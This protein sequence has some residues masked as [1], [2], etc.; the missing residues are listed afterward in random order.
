MKIDRSKIRKSSSDVPSDCQKLIQYLKECSEQELLIQLKQINVWYFGKCEL[1]HWIDVLDRFDHI[2][3]EVA[4]PVEGK[5]WLNKRE[6]IHEILK[7]TSLLIEHSYARHLYNSVEHLVSLMDCG[8]ES[9]ILSVLNLI[10]VF[11]KRSNYLSRMSSENRKSLQQRLFTLG[12]TWGGSEAGYALDQCCATKTNENFKEGGSLYFEYYLEESSNSE[13][14][15][16]ENPTKLNK[17]HSIYLTNLQKISAIPGEVME[18]ILRE[19]NVPKDVQISL[20]YRLRLAH[21]MPKL[22]M[23]LHYVQLR[24]QAISILVYSNATDQVNSLVYDGFVEEIVNTLE[25][26]HEGNALFEVK[27]S[28]LKTLTAI[29]H[30]D[31][32]P[33]LNTIIEYTGASSYHGFLPTLVRKCI[34]QMTD[35][36]NQDFPQ[37]YATALFSF[38]YHLAS[39]E[40]GCEALVSCG[41]MESLLKVVRWPGQDDHI[42]FVTRAV[43][44]IDLITNLDMASFQTHNGLNVLVDRL[45]NEVKNCSQFHGP[46]ISMEPVPSVDAGQIE[47]ED[48]AVAKPGS[49]K[50]IEDV[51]MND[52]S[53]KQTSSAGNVTIAKSQC[54]P[55]RAA[56]LKSI[57]NFL[58]KTI[59][60]PAFADYT[61]SL[62]EE[63]LQFSLKLIISNAEYYGALLFLLATDVVTVYIFHEPSMLSSLQES[64]LTGV[65]LKSLIMKDVPAT[66]EN[67]AS[68]PNTLSALCLNTAG[69]QAFIACKPFERLFR[70]LITPEYLPAMK[71]RRSSDPQGDT[72]MHLGT[73][74][75]ELMRHQPTLKTDAMK[76]I[77]QLLVKLC[78]MGNDPKLIAFHA[79]DKSKPSSTK[80]TTTE[81]Q[82]ISSSSTL[83][84]PMSDEDMEEEFGVV[85][86]SKIEEPNNKPE[87]SAKAVSEKRQYIPMID[88]LL[89]VMKFLENI[90][91]NNGT[92]DHCTEFVSL[93]GLEPLLDLLNL[94]NMPLEFPLLPACQSL[95]AVCKSIV[96]LSQ[97][98]VLF[99]QALTQLD[100][101]LDQLMPLCSE[102]ENRGSI[103]LRELASNEQPGLAMH[104]KS[105]TPLLHSMS[106]THAYINMFVHIC[107]GSQSEVRTMS[108]NQWGSE[109]GKRVLSKLSVLYTYLVWESSV[110]LT[111]CTPNLNDDERI[112]FAR[113]DLNRLST[114]FKDAKTIKEVTSPESESS[115]QT[116]STLPSS[117]IAQLR[118]IKWL[119]TSS[120]HLGRALAELFGLLVHQCIAPQQ[121]LRRHPIA[122]QTPNLPSLPA[123]L[124]A[125]QL[126][127]IL[128]QGLSWV[129]P[130]EVAIPRLRMTFY[131]CAV[132]F[133]A[134]M[135][136][137][138]K[139]S[140]YHLM[141]QQFEMASGLNH[142]FQRFQW[143]LSQY[144]DN[145]ITSKVAE[146][147]HDGIGEFLESWLVLVEKMVNVKTVLESAH[148]LP[149]HST[150]PGFIKFNPVEFLAK[151]QKLAFDAVKMLWKHKILKLQGTN[152]AEKMLK[153]LCHIFKGESTV[154]E[155]LEKQQATKAATQP[156]SK[157]SKS[158]T[159]TSEVA[160]PS[161]LVAASRPQR[162]TPQINPGYVQQIVDMGF[163]EDQA[164]DALIHC[165]NNLVQATDYVLSHPMPQA[166]P[167]SEFGM[168]VDM[169]EEDMMI[170]AIALSL[171]ENILLQDQGQ[172]SSSSSVVTS[173][174]VTTTTTLLNQQK[175]S[176]KPAIVAKE[177]PVTAIAKET[178]D[179]FTDE[180]L[181]GCLSMLID[182]PDIVHTTYDLISSVGSRN[183]KLWRCNV[184]QTICKEVREIAERLLHGAD[185]ISSKTSKEM[186][187]RFCT[188]EDANTLATR[189]HLLVLLAQEIHF[190]VAL[191]LQ[192]MKVVEHLVIL[193][194]AVNNYLIT[195]DRNEDAT[196]PRWLPSLVLLLDQYERSADAQQRKNSFECSH[197]WKWFDDRTGRWCN[198]SAS[199]NS[200]IDNAYHNGDTS[201]RFTAG[202]RRYIVLFKVMVQINEDTSNRRPI[203]LDVMAGKTEQD[204]SS[205]QATAAAIDSVSSPKKGK[206]KRRSSA[207]QME[208]DFN[209]SEQ[210]QQQSKQKTT[211]DKSV[212]KG[213]TILGLESYQIERIV[214]ACSRLMAAPIDSASLNAVMRLTLRL[215]RDYKMAAVFSEEQGPRAL[216]KLTEAS[217]FPGA[218]L[219]ATLLLRHV[220]EDMNTLQ[221]VLDT[222]VCSKTHGVGNIVSGVGQNS[223]GTKELN[224]VMRIL[225]PAACRC[226]DLFKATAKKLLRLQIKDSRSNNRR[227]LANDDSEW[228]IAPN[229]P[230]ILKVVQSV[231]SNIN[232]DVHNPLRDLVA[233]LL[234]SLVEL[235]VQ[236][237]KDLVTEPSEKAAKIDEDTES[238]VQ[239]KESEAGVG[240]VSD[241][242]EKDGCQRLSSGNSQDV[243]ASQSLKNKTKKASLL[244]LSKKKLFSKSTLLK[245][246]AEMAK[247]YPAVAKLISE[248]VYLSKGSYRMLKF[249]GSILAFIFD[250]LLPMVNQ[251]GTDITNN[252]SALARTLL[253]VIGSS[254]QLADVQNS[255]IMELKASLSRALNLQES[256]LKHSRLQAIF[257]LIV[258]IIESSNPQ[259][260]PAIGNVATMGFIKLLIRKGVITDLAKTPHSLDL[261]SP[262]LVTTINSMLKPLEKLS[263]LANHQVVAGKGDKD[264]AKEATERLQPSAGDQP[265]T[266]VASAG[267]ATTTTTTIA[268]TSDIR[269]SREIEPQS[270]ATDV[271]E[272]RE[273]A[274]NNRDIQ[275]E[276]QISS[277]ERIQ[278]VSVEMAGEGVDE[279][280]DTATQ[281]HADN[282]S[283]MITF[284][285]IAHSTQEHSHN[286]EDGHDE[287]VDH[288]IGDGDD[289]IIIEEHEGS[290]MDAEFNADAI[291][292]T[293][294]FFHDDLDPFAAD[295][296]DNNA[297]IEISFPL[298]PYAV[299]VPLRSRL[300]DSH[301]N[302]TGTSSST[303]SILQHPLL[304]R[305]SNTDTRV[306]AS[307]L[308][309]GTRATRNDRL[310]QRHTHQTH[311]LHIHNPQAS[312]SNFA[313][314]L[315][316]DNIRVL[317]RNIDE[318][319]G[320]DLLVDLFGDNGDSFLSP[321]HSVPN[322]LNRWE[323]ECRLLDGMG[324]HDCVNVIKPDIIKYLQKLQLEELEVKKEEDKKKKAEAAEKA[325]KN[326]STD[327]N[328]K[329][330]AMTS[331]ATA[332]TMTSSST[333]TTTT[334]SIS[335]N[336]VSQSASE[337]MIGSDTDG[338]Q[339][340]VQ[341]MPQRTSTTTTATIATSQSEVITRPQLSE[342]AFD[343]LGARDSTIVHQG[344]LQEQPA[345]IEEQSTSFM[346]EP[347]NVTTAYRVPL[348]A[349]YSSAPISVIQSAAPRSDGLEGANSVAPRS[350]TAELA[351]DLATAI[352]SQLTTSSIIPPASTTTDSTGNTLDASDISSSQVASTEATTS[353]TTTTE[354]RASSFT[355]SDDQQPG[356]SG[357]QNSDIPEGVDP[358]FLAALP[359]TI[360]EEVLRDHLGTR[361]RPQPQQQSGSQSQRPEGTLTD[362]SPEFLAALPPE[363]QEE[364]LEQQRLERARMQAAQTTPDQPVDAAAFIRNL[365]PSLRRQ[366]LADMD[367]SV[368]AILPP[369]VNS[370]AMGLRRELEQRQAQY[371]QERAFDQN[372]ALSMFSQLLRHSGD[373]TRHRATDGI[374][375]ARVRAML[376]GGNSGWGIR[377]SNADQNSLKKG[378]NRQLIDADSVAC[379]IV[380][381]FLDEPK[382][383]IG[384][385]HRVLKN[386]SFHKGTRLWIIKAL[387]SVINR[388]SGLDQQ[389][390][391]LKSWSKSLHQKHPATSSSSSSKR[392]GQG[393]SLDQSKLV[394]WLTRSL[395][396]SFGNR[397]DLFD[398][399]TPPGKAVDK[400]SY[401]S[402]HPHAASFV[403]KHI[404][405]ALLFLAKNFPSSFTPY[406]SKKEAEEEEDR[407]KKGINKKESLAEEDQNKL[408]RDRSTDM[409]FWN[410]LY[411]LNSAGPGRKG[412]MPMK[413]NKELFKDDVT[414][415]FDNSPLAQLLSMLSH[416]VIKRNTTLIDKLLRLL[417]VISTSLP[418]ASKPDEASSTAATNVIVE[419]P[420]SAMA[421]SSSPQQQEQQHQQQQQPQPT[422]TFAAEDTIVERSPLVDAA[423]LLTESNGDANLPDQHASSS[424]D[425][426]DHD[427][428]YPGASHFSETSSVTS[429]LFVE[430]SPAPVDPADH[431]HIGPRSP[432]AE[433]VISCLSDGTFAGQSDISG[434]ATHEEPMEIDRASHAVSDTSSNGTR[435]SPITVPII[436]MQSGHYH[437]ADR[438]AKEPV[439]VETQLRLAVNVLTSGVCSEDGLEDTTTL[440]LQ[441]S[442]IDKATRDA[443]LSLL[444]DGARDI[445]Y[446]LCGEIKRLLVELK[447]Y[448][449]L[450][451]SDKDKNASKDKKG[452][453]MI[454]INPAA[455]RIQPR[456]GR[457]R[458]QGIQRRLFNPPGQRQA[459]KPVI[460]DLHLPS[461][462]NLTGKRSCQSLLLRVLKVI[463]QLREAAKKSLNK[464]GS[465]PRSDL[466]RG[467]RLLHGLRSGRESLRDVVAAL[468]ADVEAMYELIDRYDGERTNQPSRAQQQ[469]QQQA[470]G[471]SAEAQPEPTAS[472]SEP[473]TDPNTQNDV[474][475]L[476]TVPI[477]PRL[478]SQIILDELWD[479]IGECLSE[480]AETSDAN[481]VLILQPAVEAFFIV[482]AADKDESTDKN[483]TDASSQQQQQHQQ[484]QQDQSA[485]SLSSIDL[486]PFSP[487]SPGPPLSPS[488]QSSTSIA[489]CDLAPDT[490]KFLKF[491]ETHRV[492]LNQIL[493]QSTTPLADGPFAVLV[494]HTRL[495]DFD[496]KRRYFR[497]ELEKL[498]KGVRREDMAVHVRREHV[499]EDSYRELHRK[500]KD[501][502]KNRLYIVFDGEEG[503]DA[504]GLLREWY[505]IIARE[506][507]NPNYALFTTSQG[508]RNTYLPSRSSHC[509][510]NHLSYFKFVG[511]IV[512]KAI[513]DNKLLD[514][515]FTRSFYKHILDKKVNYTDME[516][517]DY[518]FYQ[519]LVYLLDNEVKE[520]GYELTFSVEVPVFGLNEIH[521]LK[522]D[523][524]NVP[525]TEESKREYVKLVCQE[526]MTGSIRQQI[527]SFLEGFYEII[528]K[529][530][531]SI[532][533][534]QELELL[535]AGLPTIDIEDLRANTEYHKYDCNSL[536]IQ[537]FW[538]ALRAFDQADRAKFLQFVTGTSKVPLQG[539][540][541]LEGM[542]GPQKFQIHRDDRSTER[543]PS[544]HTC[545]NQLDLPA[546]NT[547]EKLNMQLLKAI[548][549]CPEGF[550]L[551]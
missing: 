94:A 23:R 310:G 517:E 491:A 180:L 506:M 454:V 348:P 503:Q 508:D 30:L 122:L 159:T 104:H 426:A 225:G 376:P 527:D 313:R 435:A 16:S 14:T 519:G 504:G 84:D 254:S 477:L 108:V 333:T 4:K 170:R 475:S 70:I 300:M 168:D 371:L 130:D 113:D 411:R 223:I 111:L 161:S 229:S 83:D 513:Y 258:T 516:A 197:I 498:D 42:T 249:E 324:V 465:Q 41:L 432:R 362:V 267:E 431:L 299:H 395:D 495:L 546:Y 234:D 382:L 336:S 99:K 425:D 119:L 380:L 247:T 53:K 230:Q 486:P 11:S 232:P 186:T 457:G 72:A 289:A 136:F 436:A 410:I 318:N 179:V 54:L 277:D 540:A 304:S 295:N 378:L 97:D 156:E 367:D 391:S 284:S 244:Y 549:E 250:C 373:R 406:L 68:L 288:V 96:V 502:L 341:M 26:Q 9:I 237:C 536:Q 7:F 303:N 64:G 89:N 415:S 281:N 252:V 115:S 220:V 151:T 488:R 548:Q 507:F 314:I 531:I 132:G 433:S 184:T 483:K 330:Q 482:H 538:R 272:M 351:T 78:E 384:R 447:E 370:E 145:A 140:P 315:V 176:E 357:T 116:K 358:S 413:T 150:S 381:L 205:G 301:A 167:H 117:R 37:Q 403:N 91:S 270:H 216:L 243:S 471:S 66:R 175:K 279:S 290:E 187:A 35:G 73:A 90:L 172:A 543:L 387:I 110:L 263:S 407:L 80:Q 515:Y 157:T 20:L 212:A 165:G 93:G 377:Q 476:M 69:L 511:R 221:H 235:H 334:S 92:D 75:D 547:F 481:A 509:N 276:F 544:A 60:D 163:T 266:T 256:K 467:M 210:Q 512:A 286:I 335:Q 259:T 240:E 50:D 8:D 397:V 185:N 141:L 86:R 278:D 139:E 292:D 442:K 459:T 429:S 48:G 398:I 65:V 350:S 147:S 59:P 329:Q 62:M 22:E 177:E 129:C 487:L 352:L 293:I 12:E 412:K 183:G 368:L 283:M 466:S 320:D 255:L 404:V 106:A 282:D 479:V 392:A 2:L 226:P 1:Y 109:L 95:S 437:Q 539:F 29:I 174:T 337:D 40:S 45:K 297:T 430:S 514:C 492:V 152:I 399:R 46:I 493:R 203:M 280:E 417:A 182:L 349:I 522:P 460:F 524:R 307:R 445:A 217:S 200:S 363:V 44:V 63:S 309:R 285:G 383:N 34:S 296:D 153:I 127:Q 356:P 24:L 213:S 470:A 528:P 550:G 423:N 190:P 316:G 125:E 248:H 298:R 275:I 137:D 402:I 386:V 450:H 343:D 15:S 361:S 369:D 453:P 542:N 500:S 208:T 169:S 222:V 355:A 233:V 396:S 449:V 372:D 268:A 194:E 444:L 87:E 196:V 144:Q 322:A 328:E 198:Y 464:A 319:L 347:T 202:R 103:L 43:R 455:N 71:R 485:A 287:A 158:N 224:F 345:S 422:V 214:R 85:I 446:A 273:D 231:K 33:R 178:L 173:V 306:S 138:E 439:V 193:L 375:F 227:G 148:S 312:G 271:D 302:E 366:V 76:A 245:L 535:I 74:M 239:Q 120:S 246:L 494:N 131:I 265:D 79:Y 339:L 434:P 545:F 100:A 121:R 308:T 478:S 518:G 215:T 497:Q 305:Q 521:D 77:I 18:Q 52:Q 124:V 126:T 340:P 474:A 327:E 39:Y 489:S 427:L 441:L 118:L 331:E 364:V 142:V 241:I 13:E 389:S 374:Q 360:R 414:D 523:G 98:S 149:T 420:E 400:G 462:A 311:T 390:K 146:G 408:S 201:V 438:A 393:Q 211:E 338:N 155:K 25:L 3:G 418:E 112:D 19:H 530:L 496:V 164:R 448:N 32:N 401:I 143:V 260:I 321:T 510:P 207:S 451:G 469:Q 17:M 21:S 501:E 526:K 326:G 354:A 421:T 56:L 394:N 242:A 101:L 49:S 291:Q 238:E 261:S 424:A 160:A 67:L 81:T 135:L 36:I 58:K 365:T 416:P 525:V 344:S 192:N 409:D 520:L 468:E 533:D 537:W 28:C 38:L 181:S 325:E 189:L 379:L 162:E 456:R 253:A 105:Q 257:N 219:L 188:N 317:S 534:E 269:E 88:Y 405:E 204:D 472:T 206:R 191:M 228:S 342:A 251:D 359:D 61:R 499:F 473:K 128:I 27:A 484:Q 323:L 264:D 388:T 195:K 428:I 452:K 154:R 47:S 505:L 274:D 294:N 262:Y 199:N 57:L 541:A 236:D 458:A 82:V 440:L 133:A 171:G 31:R 419:E 532:F 480:L 385:L 166:Q 6:L 218:V 134:P 123:R 51:E 346:T 107:R 332:A 10:Y 353:T 463:I 443:I 551:A 114:P 529:R 461:M 102:S 55:Q 5:T 490:Q 209:S